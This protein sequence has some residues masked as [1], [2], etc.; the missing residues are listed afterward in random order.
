L[1]FLIALS[2]ASA[3]AQESAKDAPKTQS[4]KENLGQVG[5]KLSNPLASLWALSMSFNMP[6]FYDG[7]VN[8][9][10]PELGATLLFQPVMPIPL[11]G[12]GDDEWRL[13]TRPIIPFIFSKP[14]PQDEEGRAIHA[15]FFHTQP[16]GCLAD[17]DESDD[18][19]QQ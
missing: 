5:A 15:L 12:S 10:D 9:G 7:D 14:I 19:L 18:Y 16:A 6:Q 2:A 1:L 8:T 4:G 11:F 13:I 17:R 3:P